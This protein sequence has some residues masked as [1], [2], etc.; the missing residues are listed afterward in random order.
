VT[1]FTCSIILILGFIFGEADGYLGGGPGGAQG[2]K[3]TE[4]LNSFTGKIG[5]G[6]ILTLITVGYLIFALRFK[7]ETFTRD[8][9]ASIKKVIPGIKPGSVSAETGGDGSNT[10]ER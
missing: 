1:K 6:I 8:I 2:L 9:P 4:W 7:P 3:I 5:T 10:A